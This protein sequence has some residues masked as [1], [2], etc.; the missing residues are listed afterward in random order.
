MKITLVLLAA[1]SASFGLSAPKHVQHEFV[2]FKE[3]YGKV[4]ASKSEEETRFRIFQ[5]N[6]YRS[7][8]ENRARRS[9]TVG[10][11][12]FSDLT[13]Q[14]FVSTYLGYKP[15]SAPVT[16]VT[17]RISRELPD[18][19]NWV[20]AGAVTDVKNQGQCGSCWA[21]ATTEQIE[22]YAQINT[23]ELMDLSAQQVTSCT[24]NPVQCGG[25]G[26]CRGSVTQLGFSYLQLFGHMAEADYPYVSGT[27]S[28]DEDCVYD[29]S[30]TMVTLTGYNT[31]PANNHDA[32]MTHLAEVGPL[33]IAVDASKWGS[34]T[35]GVF[36]GCDFDENISI[37]HGVQLVGYGTDFSALGT[38]DYWLV[39]NSWG[40]SWGEDGYIRLSRSSECG[41]NSTPMD[42]T[43]CVNG[44][45]TEQQTVCGMC[46]MLLDASYP[47]GV[48][49]V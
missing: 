2:A 38:Y 30:K 6:Y 7:A 33:S 44:P 32:V 47:I 24:P 41:V 40:S 45:N 10:I 29:P 12:Q 34:Y 43:A 4:Y 28:Q 19:V 35:G 17:A 21:F 20:E 14:E 37:N 23:G 22:S 8:I 15:M 18:S 49:K 13:H 11:T 36:N 16:N 31:L 26:G 48:K 42:G 9:Y 3:K 27:T 46:G 39:R 1:V 25:V 5:E